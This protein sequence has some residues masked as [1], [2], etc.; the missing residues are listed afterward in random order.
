MN[1]FTVSILKTISYVCVFI[2]GGYGIYKIENDKDKKSGLEA[3]VIGGLIPTTVIG[4]IRHVFFS[5]SVIAGGRFFELECGGTNLGIAI[6]SALALY[7]KSGLQ[8]LGYLILAFAIYLLMGLV[9]HIKYI[10]GKIGMKIVFVCFIALLGYF[11]YK[12][13]EVK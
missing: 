1:N 13:L 8:C 10:N 9:S 6:A 7:M 4:F 5:G 11:T 2:A 3:F 12:A